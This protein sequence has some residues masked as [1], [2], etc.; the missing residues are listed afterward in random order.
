MSSFSSLLQLISCVAIINGAMIR[1]YHLELNGKSWSDAKQ[2]CDEYYDGLATI[3]T[4]DDFNSAI[5]IIPTVIGQEWWNIRA[6]IGL[7][8]LVVESLWAWDDN[9]TC[10]FDNT[11]GGHDCSDFWLTGEPNNYANNEDCGEIWW[12]DDAWVLNDEPCPE[13]HSFLCN[14]P[15]EYTYVYN[16]TFLNWTDAESNCNKYHGGMA[17]VKTTQDLINA[18]SVIPLGV[19]N[20]WIGLSDFQDEGTWKWSNG[21]GCAPVTDSMN[22]SHDCSVFWSPGQPDDWQTGEDCGEMW[23]YR[24]TGTWMFNDLPCEQ[25]HASLCIQSNTAHPTVQPTPDIE[26]VHFAVSLTQRTWG[27]S[28]VY[29]EENYYGLVS[30]LSDEDLQEITQMFPNNQ[31]VIGLHS[32]WIGLN[33]LQQ[34][35]VWEWTDGAECNVPNANCTALWGPGEPSNFNIWHPD[36]SDGE[37][38]GVLRWNGQLSRWTIG[39][40]FCD[41]LYATVCSKDEATWNPSQKSVA[42]PTS[43]PT[44][45]PTPSPITKPTHD[46]T[47]HRV[48]VNH[49]V[50]I[51]R[52]KSNSSSDVSKLDIV[53]VIIIILLVIALG[54]T[55]FCLIRFK[56]MYKRIGEINA[57]V[58]SDA[59]HNQT[60]KSVDEHDVK[61][62]AD[63]E[64]MAT[65]IN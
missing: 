10:V 36:Q 47:L 53:L 35:G 41:N 25:T 54:T 64:H 62:I 22:M 55:L 60:G 21:D 3:I 37:D 52:N 9:T 32:A 7:N 28:L 14:K 5:F 49:T 6:W 56:K 51:V 15:F 33:D 48:F 30:I 50:Y 29:C 46:P 58:A 12:H 17:T 57:Y 39:D 65:T 16:G 18:I 63:D 31:D 45:R 61:F 26:N 4:K 34:E 2:F 43:K 13:E 44:W 27:E 1:E 19:E 11:T 59:G 40:K 42:T 23:F 20:V 8:D 24:D 38:C